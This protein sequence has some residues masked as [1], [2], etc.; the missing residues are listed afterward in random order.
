M[1]VLGDKRIWKEVEIDCLYLF[2]KNF[3]LLLLL[4]LWWTENV[5]AIEWL[6]LTIITRQREIK[7]FIEYGGWKDT[8]QIFTFIDLNYWTLKTLVS[9]KHVTKI[10]PNA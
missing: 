1:S 3:L 4:Q 7:N 8:I 9:I 5:A 6:V 2:N 10:F